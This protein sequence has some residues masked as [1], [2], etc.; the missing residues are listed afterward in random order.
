MFAVVGSSGF[1]TVCSHFSHAFGGLGPAEA[2]P[3][4]AGM[5]GDFSP[6]ADTLSRP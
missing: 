2:S 1:R 4:E 5:G 6:G 3:F